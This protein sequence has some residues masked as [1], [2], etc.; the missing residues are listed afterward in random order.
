MPCA[1]GGGAGP[2]HPRRLERRASGRARIIPAFHE[3]QRRHPDA[4]FSTVHV[5]GKPGLALRSLNG[6]VVGV[7]SV[8]GTTTIARLWLCTSLPKLAGWNRS[9]LE[10]D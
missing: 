4:S 1:R 7:L 5:N 6:E 3:L 10:G 9:R 2:A 8:D